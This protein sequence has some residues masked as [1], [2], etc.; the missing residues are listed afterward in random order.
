MD[1]VRSSDVCGFAIN[2]LPLKVMD[3]M[4]KK[5][6]EASIGVIPSNASYDA[7]ANETPA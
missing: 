7:A 4:V 1:L 2:W 5:Q 3:Y 6:L